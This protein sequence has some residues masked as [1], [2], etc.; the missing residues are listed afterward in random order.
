MKT[1]RTTIFLGLLI[2]TFSI[3]TQV[4]TFGQQWL[5]PKDNNPPTDLFAE[6][7]DQNDVNLFW[8][9]PSSG[10]SAYLH[11]DSGE[12][13]TSFG[14]FLQPVEHDYATKYDPEHIAA[15]DGW[16]I[17]T[18]RFYVTVPIASIK[19]KIWTG[20]NATEFHSQ[21]VPTYNIN[22][23]TEITLDTP[24]TIDASTQL[25]A[26][27]NIDMPVPGPV[28]GADEGPAISGYG[29]LFRF[30]GVWDNGGLNWNI[31]IQVEEPALP[32]VLHWDNGDN[33]NQFGNFLQ[34]AEYDF[35]SKWDPEHI[36]AY[37]GWTINKV[38]VI[39]SNPAATVKLKIWTGQEATEIYSQDVTGIVVNDWTEI[40]LDTPQ[41]I[42]ASTQLWVGLNVDMPFPGVVMGCDL[43]PAIDGFGDMYR[44]NGT[45]YSDFDYNWNIQFEV[46]DL[47]L[48]GVDGLLGYNIYRDDIKLNED[49]WGSTSYVDENMLNGTYDYHVTA[50][51]DEGE[52]EPSNTVEVVVAQPVIAY[53][54]SMALVDIYNNCGGSGWSINTLW[55]EGPVSEWYGVTTTGTRV[56]QLWLHSRGVSG[57]IPTSV[58]DLTALKKL[59][60]ESNGGL[61]SI[62]ESI[63]DCQALEELWLGWTPITVIPESLGSLSN[64]IQL[65]LGQMVNPLGTL[66]ESLCELE[67]LEWFALGTSGLDS[68][69]RNFGNLTTVKSCFL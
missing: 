42:D 65:H 62:P 37:D 64:L 54:D 43:G 13:Y 52:S 27:L 17:T 56:T 67:S 32:T 39:L 6:V 5:N 24:I 19:L 22:S 31:Q 50:I 45:W 20:P 8:T 58:G 9:Q 60:L 18:M 3:F 63:G 33:L 15:Y 28:M 25:W 44:F 69:P 10:G 36:S 59:H 34:P 40:T 47:N 68:L 12:N 57:D 29:D 38:R 35:A 2:F 46:E 1:N 11:W 16:T 49:T 23:W 66:P 55:L 61:N 51:Y 7:V 14:N 4:S 53:A 41:T 21:D 26:G 48:R 30:N